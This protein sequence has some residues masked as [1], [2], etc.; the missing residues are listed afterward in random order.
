MRIQQL[1]VGLFKQAFCKIFRTRSRILHM[2]RIRKKRHTDPSCVRAPSVGLVIVVPHCVT[3]ADGQL[4]YCLVE[5]MP[6][7]M[8]PTTAL[9]WQAARTLPGQRW[10]RDSTAVYVHVRTTICAPQTLP[11][12]TLKTMCLRTFREY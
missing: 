1:I 10:M 7:L 2:S 3:S 6:T 5:T 4:N 9:T 11:A 8:F 12:K